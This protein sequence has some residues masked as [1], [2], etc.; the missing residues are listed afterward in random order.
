MIDTLKLRAILG[1]L[2]LLTVVALIVTI[3]YINWVRA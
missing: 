1:I 3:G 2:I